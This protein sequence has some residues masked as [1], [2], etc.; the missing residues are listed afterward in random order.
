M[1]REAQ[2]LG[3]VPSRCGH[4]FTLEPHGPKEG[5]C[6]FD[7]IVHPHP[8]VIRGIVACSGGIFEVEVEFYEGTMAR[9]HPPCVEALEELHAGDITQVEGMSAQAAGSILSA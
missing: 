9:A 3:H 7:K 4:G 8:G 5:P 1:P 6:P 2:H